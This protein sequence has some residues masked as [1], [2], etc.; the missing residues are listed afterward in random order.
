M[1]DKKNKTV[2]WVEKIALM[3][4]L[5]FLVQS[6]F[7]DIRVNYDGF[8]KYPLAARALYFLAR[9]G[10]NKI[11]FAVELRLDRTDAEGCALNYRVEK[12]LN[13]CIEG[14]FTEHIPQEPR[15]FKDTLKSYIAAVLQGKVIFLTMAASEINFKKAP[16]GENNV[17][18]L[19]SHPLNFL[20]R[21]FYR[22][23]GLVIR[24][25][26]ISMRY[27]TFYFR[28]FYY[29]A[30]F[31]LCKSGN[32]K[33]KSNISDIKPAIWV[34]YYPGHIHASWIGKIRAQGFDVVNYF[35]RN[36]TQITSK[37]LKEIEGRSSKWIDAHFPSLIRISRLS[38]SDLKGLI[39]VLFL[40]P[41]S[42]QALLKTFRFEYNFLFLIYKSVFLRYKVKILIQHQECSWKQGVQALAVERAGGIMVGYHWSAFQ[43]YMMSVENF[44]QHVYF[45]W[46]KMMGELLRKKDAAHRYILPSGIWSAVNGHGPERKNI[47]AENV[48]FVISVFDSEARYNLF[49]SPG[50]L[51]D[52]Y[53]RVLN[54]V[55]DSPRLGCIIKSKQLCPQSLLALPMGKE[56]VGLVEMLRGQKRLAIF[57]SFKSP[58]AAAQ[59]SDL[60]V[61]Y[62]INSACAIAATMGGRAAINWDCSGFKKHPFYKCPGQKGVFKTLDTLEEAILKASGGDKTIGDY[63]RWQKYVN[64]FGVHS[65]VD[66]VADFLESYMKESM[67]TGDPGHSLDFAVKK[68]LAD[69]RV[70]VD[71]YQR[72]DLWED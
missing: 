36:D 42:R 33:P 25:P 8:Q 27:I 35:D 58:L 41:F 72:E 30:Y 10:L 48:D 50:S 63:S 56:I 66:R 70:G 60:S 40:T 15:R 21:G 12:E 32:Y 64:Y 1:Q 13:D 7:A 54:I 44:P 69:N 65:G 37:T 5:L 26:V 49:Q 18:C 45:A 28:P 23:R 67:N 31:L 39:S 20:L 17:I 11:F 68:Y 55:K 47:F 2:F 62:G 4:I 52:F 61:G 16:A 29:L 71:F 3:D 9:A 46:G 24:R 53:L 43:Y 22:D 38:F 57:E 6:S 34:E 14:F 19:N 51:S 59:S